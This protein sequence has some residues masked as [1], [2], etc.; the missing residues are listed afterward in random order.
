VRGS[1]FSPSGPLGVRGK[2]SFKG[3]RSEGPGVRGSGSQGVR[4][5]GCRVRGA[6]HPG[7][8]HPCYGWTF[9]TLRPGYHCYLKLA[10]V[11]P[12]LQDVPTLNRCLGEQ[13]HCYLS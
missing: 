6:L 2:V 7:G 13:P 12:L 5:Q 4:G 11:P 1:G 8:M 10:E 3:F 9:R